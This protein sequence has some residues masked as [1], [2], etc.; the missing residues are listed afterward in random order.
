MT[1][2]HCDDCDTEIT[3]E[4]WLARL[5]AKTEPRESYH[6]ICSDCDPRPHAGERMSDESTANITFE[7]APER[8]Q[9][10]AAIELGEKVHPAT[11]LG[12]FIYG[13]N[14]RSNYTVEMCL[15][16]RAVR[17]Q[18]EQMYRAKGLAAYVPAHAKTARVFGGS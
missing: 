18:L 2:F 14:V 17:R 16:D 1:K 9:I 12:V 8:D 10:L 5:R 4:N 15:N 13:D 3:D 6:I 11:V 7:A